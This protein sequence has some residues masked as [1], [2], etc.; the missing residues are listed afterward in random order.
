MIKAKTVSK[1]MLTE[2]FCL[3][4]KYS[5]YTG[6]LV[7]KLF[8]LESSILFQGSEQLLIIFSLKYVTSRVFCLNLATIILSSACIYYYYVQ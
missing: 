4:G 8:S 2:S 3:F 7:K 6:K 1:V 5:F